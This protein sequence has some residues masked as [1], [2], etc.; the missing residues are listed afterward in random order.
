M[1]SSPPVQ[2]KLPL[3]LNVRPKTEKS[4]K[5]WTIECSD[6][7]RPEQNALYWRSKSGRGNVGLEIE[8]DTNALFTLHQFDIS[9]QTDAVR[10]SNQRQFVP[11]RR[12]A[13]KR[14]LI[15]N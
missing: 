11:R 14:K 2:Q 4:L 6:E 3:V 7:V 10:S 15:S 8:A 13:G 9:L 12:H 1:L 5:F